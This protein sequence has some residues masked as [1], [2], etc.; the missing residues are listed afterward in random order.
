MTNYAGRSTLLD[1]ALGVVPVHRPSRGDECSHCVAQRRWSLARSALCRAADR[2]R[3]HLEGRRSAATASRTRHGI[4]RGIYGVGSSNSNRS[5]PDDLAVICAV[6]GSGPAVPP[7]RINAQSERRSF[8]LSADTDLSNPYRS[9]Q[10]H[11]NCCHTGRHTAASRFRWGVVARRAPRGWPLCW[12][13]G[14]HGQP[15]HGCGSPGPV[16]CS[17]EASLRHGGDSARRWPRCRSSS[18]RQLG[19]KAR[20][21]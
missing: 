14:G 20:S 15:E 11:F 1:P 13:S 3:P 18:G 16:W 8:A 4:C 6:A 19:D 10:E 9:G 5:E 17:A 2:P 21:P 12:R 7:E